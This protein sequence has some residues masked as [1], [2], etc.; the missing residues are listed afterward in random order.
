MVV[1]LSL[2]FTSLELSSRCL[3][4]LRVSSAALSALRRDVAL[5]DAAAVAEL[6]RRL[7][8]SFRV[9]RGDPPALATLDGEDVDR[10]LRSER[11]GDAASRVAAHASVRESL[12]ARQRAFRQAPGLV[13]D[14]RDMGTVVFPDAC[15]KL[16][17]TASPQERAQRRYKQLIAK[18]ISAS[19][20]GLFEEIEE[21]DRRDTN[22]AVAPLAP[23]ADAVV[24]DTSDVSLDAVFDR[25]L[26]LALERIPG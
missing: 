17:L 2:P 15:L 26:K 21:R 8:V 3:S 18:G 24:V 4:C 5:D 13:A 11:C 25:V 7:D 1:L 22:R 23:A 12:L 10:E 20:H 19:L 9:G 6:A 14:G 16:F